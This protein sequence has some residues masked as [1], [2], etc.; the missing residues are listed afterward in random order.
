MKKRTKIIGLITAV[1]MIA[2][3]AWAGTISQK[4]YGIATP[5]WYG[6]SS[7]EPA[8]YYLAMPTLSANDTACGIA[9]TQTLTN[10]TMAGGSNTFSNIA[11]SSLASAVQD[12]MP[13]AAVSA[14]DGGDGTA[15]VTV[16][17]KD[18][19]G[20]DLADVGI[21]HVW[22]DDTE[23]GAPTAITGLSATTGT[24]ITTHTANADLEVATDTSGTI[25]LA[26]NNGGAGTIYIMVA[27][28]GLIYSAEVVITSS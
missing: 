14:V 10:K 9:A 15:T 20:N 2:A 24:V 8:S 26:A 16:Q 6:Y 3:V 23:Y 18:G 1:L 17:L 19:A 13:Y 5:Y 25:V 7:G 12:V 21:V 4:P 11:M 28:R 27:I 22:T